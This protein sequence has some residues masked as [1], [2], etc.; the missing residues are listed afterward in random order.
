MVEDLTEK[1]NSTE[2]L[3]R[4]ITKVEEHVEKRVG[5]LSEKLERVQTR[6]DGLRD[7]VKNLED[8]ENWTVRYATTVGHEVRG[9]MQKM[10]N[11]HEMQGT[12]KK[13]DGRLWKVSEQACLA[14]EYAVRAGSDARR[15]VDEDL[16]LEREENRGLK[17]KLE[18]MEGVV[19]RESTRRELAEA[20]VNNLAR[21][22]QLAASSSLPRQ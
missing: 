15:L 7:D 9:I 2:D 18:Q 12:I 16:R 13:L 6:V 8:A 5:R 10:D 21:D 20:R 22:L 19:E 1:S 14:K 3:N 4:R 17:R 11:L